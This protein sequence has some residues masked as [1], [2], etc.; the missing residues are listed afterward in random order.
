MIRIFY[1]AA[2]IVSIILG[3]LLLQVGKRNNVTTYAL[4]FFSVSI[5]V[6]GSA[7]GVF[8]D[9]VE[10]A[11]VANIASYYGI[12]FAI[13]FLMMCLFKLTDINVNP[14]LYVGLFG[15]NTV[16]LA[17]ICTVLG[18]DW[19]YGDLTLGDY[20][21]VAVLQTNHFG[22]MHGAHYLILA[23]YNLMSFAVVLYV[24]Y[25]NR[26][27]SFKNIALLLGF[28]L[29]IIAIYVIE[30]SLPQIRIDLVPFGMVA[31]ECVVLVCI[32]RLVS[33]DVSGNMMDTLSKRKDHGYL[34]IDK[35]RHYI[36]SDPS[37]ELFFPELKK[38][39]VDHRI[40]DRF[41]KMKEIIEEVIKKEE[42]VY[43]VKTSSGVGI[44]CSSSDIWHSGKHRGYIIEFFDDSK[45]LEHMEHLEG[46][47]QKLQED[48]SKEVE[49]AARIQDQMILGMATMVEKRDLSTGTHIKRTSSGIRIIIGNLKKEDAYRHLSEEYWQSIVRTAPLHDIGK[50]TIDD[51]ILRKPGKYTKEEFEVMKLHSVNGSETVLEIMEGIQNQ[52]YKNT[53]Y[54]IARFHHERWDGTGYPEGL[55]GEVIPLEARIMAIADVLDALVSKRCYKKEIPFWESV[56]VI[57][58]SF[59]THF[60]PSLRGCFE[61]SIEQLEEYYRTELKTSS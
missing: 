28:E 4:L 18:N 10:W 30:F 46:Y 32:W 45:Q 12:Y 7:L 14:W 3:M 57:R 9:S 6:G 35:N 40:D 22:P 47:N 1:L 11:V 59:G 23:F 16:I 53:A 60:D 5:S 51:T 15:L 27:A 58:N 56:E 24:K 43:N 44:R 25:R 20:M 49:K 26:K 54:N 17:S 55:S 39:R 36:A 42:T 31:G 34:V 33:Y 38:M 13:L 21:G 19:F 41:P 52:V 29:C 2:F 50:I 61:N 8:A 37:A 48:V